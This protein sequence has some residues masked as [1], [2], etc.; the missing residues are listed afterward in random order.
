[1]STP[2]ASDSRDRT[3]RLQ[4]RT[5]AFAKR[6][7]KLCPRRY[8][9]DPSRVIWRQLIRAAPAASGILD[10]A[11]EAS[12]TREFVYKMRLSLREMK[13]SRR[14]LL[15]IQQ[16]RLQGHDRLDDLPAEARQLASIFG[17]I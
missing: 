14:W 15:F 10:E 9:D 7:L 2:P 5:F 17:A 1:M 16:C 4:Q 3:V 12:S 8:D 11:D 6:V 13:E